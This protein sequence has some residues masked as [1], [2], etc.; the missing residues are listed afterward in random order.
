MLLT[1]F[2]PFG[3]YSYEEIQ[4]NRMSGLPMRAKD[5]HFKTYVR[6]HF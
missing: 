2:A 5:E 1:S 6:T 4:T 3:D